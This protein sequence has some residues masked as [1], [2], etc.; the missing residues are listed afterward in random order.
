M[1]RTFKASEL[2]AMGLPGD[3]DEGVVVDDM[4]C[5]HSRWSVIH[6]LTF[7]LPDQQPGDAWQTTYNRP[8]TE[9]Q[10]EQPWGYDPDVTVTLV[11]LVEKTVKVWEP[12]K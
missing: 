10:Y 3:A 12:V 6:R 1:K 11:R 4:I 8:A 7:R 2:V 5:G 9:S